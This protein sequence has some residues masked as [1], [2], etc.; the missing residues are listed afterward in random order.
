MHAHILCVCVWGA[1]GQ[2]E[3]EVAGKERETEKTNENMNEN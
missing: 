1:Y 2:G 3:M